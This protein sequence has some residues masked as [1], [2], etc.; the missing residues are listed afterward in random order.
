MENKYD[1]V[2][3]NIV[4]DIIKVYKKNKEGEFVL[5][6]EISDE[7]TYSFP[8]L[9]TEFTVELIMDVD[10]NVEEYDLDAN[11]YR[12][13]DTIELR[14][15]SNPNFVK[16]IPEEM[17]GDLKEHIRHEIEHMIQHLSG[18][19][20]PDDPEDPFEYYSQPHELDAQFAG[21]EIRSRKEKKP[22]ENIA[23]NWFEKNKKKHNLSD[24]EIEII[25]KRIINKFI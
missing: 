21:F 5:P 6:E 4:N 1:D 14:I 12:D 16:K 9:G 11:Y 18:Y 25:V 3:V 24:K 8:G 13:E 20:F 22:L 23:R 17:I 2:T 15:V 10:K 7:M 19:E